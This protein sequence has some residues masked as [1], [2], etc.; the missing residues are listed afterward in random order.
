MEELQGSNVSNQLLEEKIK[1]PLKQRMDQVNSEELALATE[2][3][4][5]RCEDK[6]HDSKDRMSMAANISLYKT[7]KAME[8][9][10]N[11]IHVLRRLLANLIELCIGPEL[12]KA[13]IE[14]C[15]RWAKHVKEKEIINVAF[16]V[17]QARA[18]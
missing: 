2:C 15:G 11:R 17:G 7:W 6:L 9:N 5:T 10:P 1:R 3:E 8:L 12:D 18:V 13:V 4:K 14:N 16:V